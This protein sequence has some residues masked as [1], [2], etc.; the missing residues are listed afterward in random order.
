MAAA[1]KGAAGRESGREGGA[2]LPEGQ[3]W[4]ESGRSCSGQGE[5]LISRRPSWLQT[6]NLA[7]GSHPGAE[8]GLSCRKGSRGTP[9]QIN[10]GSQF[11]ESSAG[12][13][14]ETLTPKTGGE[15]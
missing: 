3:G 6:M 1:A 12:P 15:W 5:G 2:A 11:D 10:E 7:K 13:G 8:D 9:V 14:D 4:V